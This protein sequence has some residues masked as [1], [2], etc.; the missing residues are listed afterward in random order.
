[1]A[2]IGDL[3]QPAEMD[4][5]TYPVLPDLVGPLPEERES[6]FPILAK[7]GDDLLMLQRSLTF[8]RRSSPIF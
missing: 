6:L 2:M 8:F 5:A 3:D 7:P 4:L 1:M